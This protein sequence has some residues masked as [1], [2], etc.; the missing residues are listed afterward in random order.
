MHAYSLIHDDLPCMDNADTRRGQ[1]ANH[2]K[3]DEATAILAGDALIPLAYE[4]MSNEVNI[5]DANVRCELIFEFSKAIGGEGMVGGQALDLLGERTQLSFETMRRMQ[6]LKTG[7]M[8]EFSC[9]AGAILGN[10]KN[11]ERKALYD[12]AKKLGEVFQ[13]T[14]DLLDA[15]GEEHI[16]GKPLRADAKKTTFVSLYGV[17]EAQ[18]ESKKLIKEACEDLNVF[19]E[20]TELLKEIANYLLNRT[21]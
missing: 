19:P 11:M 1:P 20:G 5:P 7:K 18:S 13:I 9:L 14:D 8:F 4:I 3:F 17:F 12:Y 15:I 6:T 2:I 16:V 10:A 21:H